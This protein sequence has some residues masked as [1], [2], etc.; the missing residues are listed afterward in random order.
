MLLFLRTWIFF[1]AT[2]TAGGWV[3]S[4]LGLLNRGGYC[5][6]FAVF[7]FFLQRFLRDEDFHVQ[8]SK[9]VRRFARRAPMLYALLAA[10]GALGAF[11]Y[12]PVNVDGY[13]YRIPRVL[14]WLFAGRWH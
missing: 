1:C 9:W 6:L 10:A 13:A 12:L 14:H 8:T 11:L 4:A 7:L 5:G 2:L 3:L